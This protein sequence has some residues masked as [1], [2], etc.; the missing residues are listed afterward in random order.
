MWLLHDTNSYDYDMRVESSRQ[1]YP[2][3]F[4]TGRLRYARAPV[5]V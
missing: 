3:P 2:N 4:T 5:K 1:L